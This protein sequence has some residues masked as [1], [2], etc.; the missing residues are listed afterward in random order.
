MTENETER[1]RETISLAFDVDAALLV[2]LGA[3]LVARRSVALAELIKNAYDADATEVIV[4][5]VDA[6]SPSGAI[7]VEDNGNGM[8]LEDMKG[9]WMR[10]ATNDA[11]VNALSA[12]FGRP[13]TGAKG[14]GRFACGRLASRLALE[15]VSRVP[16]GTETIK[17]DFNWSDFAPGRDLTD[18]A[19]RITRESL[20]GELP[21]GTKLR[22]SG[23]ADIWTKADVA[24]LLAELGELM[25][26]D[27][28]AGS[29][30]RDTE[31]E[32]DLGFN[33]RFIAPEFPE[34][35]GT[36][37]EPL[38]EAA[39]GVLTGMVTA[40]GKPNYELH[41]RDTDNLLE[42]RPQGRP[43]Q[44]LDG[45]AFKTQMMVY[46]GNRF[47]GTGYKLADARQL[48][49]ERGGVKV[50]VDGFRVSSYGS[51]GDDWLNL[52][53]DRARR[54]SDLP[55]WLQEQA[56]G[57][58]G[59]PMLLLPGNMQLFGSVSI[60]RERNPGL[61]ASISRER[62]VENESY[63]Q[64]RRFVR[65]GIDWMTVCYARERAKRPDTP[66]TSVTEI[67]TAA[68]ALQSTR[69]T[70]SRHEAIPEDIRQEID[71]SLSEVTTLLIQETEARV[72]ELSMLRVLASAGT[73]V[74]LF[75][76]MLR[77]MARQLDGI[78]NNLESATSYVQPNH[79]DSFRR[80]VADLRSWSS[81]A[82]GQGLLV[83]L[84]VGPEARTRR[85][86]LALAPL[87][88]NL[89]RGFV[90]YLSLFGISLEIRVPPGVRTPP[91][92]EA[93]VYA[94]LLNLLTN[95]LKAVRER[96]ERR[97]RIEARA[98]QAEFTL[99]V[100]DTG[101]GVPLESREIV[102]EPFVTT[103]QPDP[104]LGV[105]TGLGLK[106]VRD[107]VRAWGGD[108]EFVDTTSPWRTTIELVIPNQGR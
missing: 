108:V 5:F 79:A 13:R 54:Q 18:I 29:I 60:S 92:H 107:L 82:I 19:L 71:A 44:D 77:Q 96:T 97:V 86:S 21:T 78:V 45:V 28:H 61:A 8:T 25:N 95:S 87:A 101:G 52:D 64:L 55:T 35:E 62:L 99:Q 93:E 104:V 105:G 66:D 30:R 36:I 34:F 10:I 91:L 20:P 16:G 47:R 49:R 88:E 90:G 73:T 89:K 69:R 65:D 57:I 23:L 102:F 6:S 4:S 43:F 58:R 98:T 70:V 53:R 42:H 80:T 81:M 48:G 100:H 27:E 22:L 50:Y 12:R 31:H 2:E 67:K 83:G 63:S 94:V 24:D 56:D 9:G 40:G 3:R 39:W 103:S 17:A 32:A 33:T 72:S 76:H 7:L 106:I 85:R 75:D 37:E 38:L 74:L 15:S 26:L 11:V 51:A 68:Q 84:L 14:I 46:Q 1:E 41:I 59:R